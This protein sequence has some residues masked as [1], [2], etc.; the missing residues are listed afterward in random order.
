[1]TEKTY[2]IRTRRNP[3]YQSQCDPMFYHELY[4]CSDGKTEVK[5]LSDITALAVRVADLESKGFVEAK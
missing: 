5:N 3:F 1:M 2:T 4:Y